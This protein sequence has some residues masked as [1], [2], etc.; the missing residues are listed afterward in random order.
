MSLTKAIAQ[1]LNQVQ[2]PIVDLTRSC[3]EVAINNGKIDEVF[4]KPVC[5]KDKKEYERN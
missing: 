1:V 4:I 5:I 2:P 3:F